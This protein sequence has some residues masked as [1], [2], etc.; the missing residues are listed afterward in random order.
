[1]NQR[2]IDDLRSKKCSAEDAVKNIKS[3][4][5]IDYGFFNGKPQACDIALAARNEEL[6]DI[7]I[8]SA[9]TLPPVPSVVNCDGEGKKFTYN[10]FHFSPL[11]RIL[12][13]IKG[14]VFYNPIIYS[15]CERYYTDVKTDPD[16][17]GTPAR[18]VSIV[19][20]TPMD[21]EGYFNFG[22]HNS[23]TYTSLMN[24][25]I[26]I[27]EVN[28]KLP[29]CH[30]GKFEKIHISEVTHVV[31]SGNPDLLEAPVPEPDEIEKKIA[32]QVMDHI[33]D[34]ACVQFGIGGV[35][36]SIG[37]LIADSDFKDLGC[38]TEMLVDSYVGLYEAGKMT[39]N[40]KNID[41]GKMTF[42]FAVG[43]SKLYRFMDNNKAIASYNV[44]YINDPANIARNDN[45]ISINSAVQID[46]YTQVNAESMGF[47]QISGN[48]GMFDFVQ[49]AYWSKG[50]RSIICIPSTYK[51]SSGE[52]KSRIVPFFDPGTIVTVP[53][54]M[55]NII[56]TEYG[57]VSLKGDSTWA[58]AEKII[59]IAHPD[60]R[61][62]LIKSAEKQKI[63]RKSNKNI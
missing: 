16:L 49:G 32:L 27:V 21:N 26:R 1:M 7:C 25:G 31:D 22:L 56:A 10:D 57:W 61:D 11:T 6:E 24:T 45:V 20:T 38:H 60:F 17:V 19:Q 36:N 23:H 59:S 47:K 14:N 55:I 15:E 30:G 12:Q 34:G 33:R 37:K 41:K 63:W 9:V 50:G 54:Q 53:R 62:D 2:L 29:W 8:I 40:R 3:G 44:G 5:W 58:R 39:G 13:E 35:P 46:L 18:D 51:K 52:I 43:G 4:S 48:G 28:E 42:T